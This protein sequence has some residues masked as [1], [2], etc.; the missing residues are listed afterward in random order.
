MLRS[1]ATLS[2]CPPPPHY[3]PKPLFGSVPV[4]GYGPW[5]DTRI[6]GCDVMTMLLQ[7]CPVLIITLSPACLAAG[8][9]ACQTIAS[10]T[11]TAACCPLPL[12]VKNK[13]NRSVGRSSDPPSSIGSHVCVA[14]G[15]AAFA[16]V[17]APLLCSC[18]LPSSASKCC[19][20]HR[21]GLQRITFKCFV[22]SILFSAP[23]QQPLTTT[24]ARSRQQRRCR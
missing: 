16:A 6:G 18:S 24:I 10:T 21:R 4:C 15:V 3:F 17:A 19:I 9:K 7:F 13:G 8:C 11:L 20:L 14:V 2:S 5:H 22:C 1:R 23:R 12:C